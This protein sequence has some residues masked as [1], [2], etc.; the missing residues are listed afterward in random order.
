[1]V[2]R[3]GCA[4][5][6]Q[7]CRCRGNDDTTQ[8]VRYLGSVYYRCEATEPC[9]VTTLTD[10][11][12][13]VRKKDAVWP[14]WILLYQYWCATSVVHIQNE[15][16]NGSALRLLPLVMM[17]WWFYYRDAVFVSVTLITGP[18]VC[19][20]SLRSRYRVS[21]RGITEGE[22]SL[23]NVVMIH[24]CCRWDNDEDGDDGIILEIIDITR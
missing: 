20:C 21:V 23:L 24:H 22:W 7:Y 6:I 1:M 11:R 15:Y 16:G 5:W 13:C 14:R 18:S 8:G 4:V 9:W 2:W 10:V 3:N 12:V 19:F 17:L